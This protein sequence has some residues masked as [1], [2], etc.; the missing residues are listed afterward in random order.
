MLNLNLDYQSPSGQWT[1][2]AGVKDVLD[3]AYADPVALDYLEP[4]RD[5]IIQLGRSWYAELAWRF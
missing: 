5:R 3:R 4:L 2:Q 1:V